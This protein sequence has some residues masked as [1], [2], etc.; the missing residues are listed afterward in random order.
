MF[1]K[2]V[3]CTPAKGHTNTAM[4]GIVVAC[5]VMLIVAC[6]IG[7]ACV[8]RMLQFIERQH[9]RQPRIQTVST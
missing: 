9:E 5:A 3:Y 2:L 1:P 4:A 8:C 7:F 6:I